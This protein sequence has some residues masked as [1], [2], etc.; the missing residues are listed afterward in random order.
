MIFALDELGAGLQGLQLIHSVLAVVVV[1]LTRKSLC[2]LSLGLPSVKLGPQK[3]SEMRPGAFR[4]FQ[5][6]FSLRND[7]LGW[8]VTPG[9]PEL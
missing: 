6:P 9:T 4:R 2:A 1:P 7:I 8:R 5:V 3:C